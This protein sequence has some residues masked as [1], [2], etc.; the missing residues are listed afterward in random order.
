[1]NEKGDDSRQ[2]IMECD[3]ESLP[4]DEVTKIEAKELSYQALF[5]SG[6]YD[7]KYKPIVWVES[8]VL[9]IKDVEQ[10]ST[11]NLSLPDESVMIQDIC[12]VVALVLDQPANDDQV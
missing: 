12:D 8:G 11:Y 5:K 9:D 2:D 3:V 10:A 1:M 4:T 7:E 6:K